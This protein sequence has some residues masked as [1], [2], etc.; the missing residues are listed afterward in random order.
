MPHTHT[1]TLTKTHTHTYGPIEKHTHTFSPKEGGLKTKT[2]LILK[3]EDMRNSFLHLLFL[4]IRLCA[5]C[6][7]LQNLAETS[8]IKSCSHVTVK[9]SGS[10]TF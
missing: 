9:V 5:A 8:E 2:V 4:V 1:H 7:K 3:P 10:R 6:Q